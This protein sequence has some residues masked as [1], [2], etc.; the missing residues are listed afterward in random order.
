MSTDP[1]PI[2]P[3]HEWLLDQAR[4]A[5]DDELTVALA[6]VVAAVAHLGGKGKVVLEVQID[7]AGSGGRMVSTQC[8]VKTKPPLPPAEPSVFFVGDGGSLVRDDPYQ[9]RLFPTRRVD[10]ETGEIRQL[11]DPDEESP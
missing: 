6:E 4:G 3:F 1:T 2:R 7:P 5:V 8:V 11:P 9:A 10:A